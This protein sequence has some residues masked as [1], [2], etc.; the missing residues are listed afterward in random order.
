M[1]PIVQ[2]ALVMLTLL[3]VAAVLVVSVIR[4][5]A[6]KGITVTLALLV[7]AMVVIDSELAFILGHF[8]LNLL[9]VVLVFS[10]GIL[11]TV[12]GIYALYRIVVLPLRKLIDSTERLAVGDLQGD[13]NYA[14]QN[15]LGQL[16]DSLRNV[17]AYQQEMAAL[18]H[19]IS[20]G[21]LGQQFKA[22]SDHDE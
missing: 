10:P 21:D 8:E 12:L 11:A 5:I 19:H 14:N 2:D 15:E 3:V 9:N 22:K 4:L 20:G 18:A 13:V 7:V 17:I 16:A 1:N 6:K